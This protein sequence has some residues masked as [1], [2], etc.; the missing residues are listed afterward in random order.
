MSLLA[1]LLMSLSPTSESHGSPIPFVTVAAGGRS[2][3]RTH[4]TAIIR[5]PTA[6]RDLWRRHVQRLAHHPAM[7]AVDFV[8]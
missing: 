7:P 4:T 8:R 5:T 6:W 3:I 1:I 2:G